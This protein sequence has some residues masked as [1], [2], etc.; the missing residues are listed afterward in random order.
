MVTRAGDG[1]ANLAMGVGFILGTL[2]NTH[3][4]LYFPESS[5][6][7]ADSNPQIFLITSKTI[8]HV[9][10]QSELRSYKNKYTL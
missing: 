4:A 6:R 10:P 1:S 8:A 7:D 3:T 2:D 5:Y 9:Q